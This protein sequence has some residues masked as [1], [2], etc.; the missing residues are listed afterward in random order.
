MPRK[1]LR[2]KRAIRLDEEIY[3]FFE[4]GH[5]F[6]EAE[7]LE[8]DESLARERWELHRDEALARWKAEGKPGDMYAVKRF[9]MGMS[10]GEALGLDCET[11]RGKVE[12]CHPRCVALFS[13]D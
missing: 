5:G 7:D 8:T 9:D 6:F 11:C 13:K 3:W 2:E 10:R 4:S 1:P 12:G